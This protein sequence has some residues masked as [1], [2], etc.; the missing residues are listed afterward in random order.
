[1]VSR[2]EGLPGDIG[3]FY[4]ALLETNRKYETRENQTPPGDNQD[5]KFGP[6]NVPGSKAKL[7]YHILATDRGQYSPLTES[8]I[9]ATGKHGQYLTSIESWIDAYRRGENRDIDSLTELSDEF[10]R[11]N[12]NS[13]LAVREAIQFAWDHQDQLL[14]QEPWF[15]ARVENNCC[16][17]DHLSLSCWKWTFTR[18]SIRA[19]RNGRGQT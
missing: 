10:L 18:P 11:T 4:E 13:L 17:D 5:E 8:W 14:Q 16:F 1:M 12:R 7:M 9:R 6:W 2:P 19:I 15:W 3:G